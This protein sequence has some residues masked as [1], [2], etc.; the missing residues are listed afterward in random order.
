MPHRSKLLLA[1]LA[2][3]FIGAVAVMYGFELVSVPHVREYRELLWVL[4]G[5]ALV[6]GSMAGL[7]MLARKGRAKPVMPHDAPT[8][9]RPLLLADALGSCFRP[10]YNT[11]RA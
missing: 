10:P 1:C 2:G 6:I 8:L 11:E 5:L 7:L 3:I 9:T 4:G